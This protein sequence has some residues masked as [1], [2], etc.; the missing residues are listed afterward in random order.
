MGLSDEQRAMLQLLLEGGQGYDDIGGL[1]GIPGEEV[2]ARARAALREIGGADP[3][4]VVGLTDYL[5]GEADPIGRADAARHLQN[6]PDANDLAT[7]LVA[8][9]RLLAPRA[10]LP[11]I[12]AL[13]T[14][15]RATAPAS[16]PELPATAP[17]GAAAAGGASLPARLSR[18]LGGMTGRRLAVVLGAAALLIVAVVVVV[19]AISGGDNGGDGGT[20]APS[21]D[22][23][24]V[25]LRPLA[26]GSGATGVAVFGQANN[27]PVLRVNLAGLQ[28][29]AKQQFYIVWLYRSDKI[30][31]PIA[32]QTAG[33]DGNVRGDAAIPSA[34]NNVLG[35][36]GCIDVSLANARDTAAALR[37]AVK[38]KAQFPAHSGESVLRGQIPPGPG[39]SAATG[40]AS[41]CAPV[42]Q[43]G[44]GTGG[45]G[46]GG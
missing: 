34:L 44:G 40:S 20:P 35:V 26:G 42:L 23:E 27:Q 9:L 2:R 37:A 46:G 6:D 4:A 13:R 30:A 19:V 33:T 41:N 25:Q 8:Q 38:G 16:V 29:T 32:R 12:P 5:L 36:F 1:L 14:G 3:D 22:L 31:F 17:A 10:E 18:P 24:I 45:T 39:E 15:R 11:E 21:S 43:T 28:P 7:R